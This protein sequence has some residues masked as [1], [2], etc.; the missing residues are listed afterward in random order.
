MYRAVGMVGGVL[1]YCQLS[2]SRP[3]LLLWE[4]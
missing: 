1:R 2:T 4:V 3:L